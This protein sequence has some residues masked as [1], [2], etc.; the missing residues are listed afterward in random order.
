[1]SLAFK[2]DEALQARLHEVLAQL[3]AQPGNNVC[4]DCGAATP[5]W[6]SIN[7]GVFICIKCAGIHR[8]LV[9]HISKVRSITLDSWTEEQ[10]AFVARIGN[11]RANS[12]YEALNHSFDKKPEQVQRC[13]RRARCEAD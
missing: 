4:A 2:T 9:T 11:I 7:L 12:V 1:M 5:K 10:V 6:S 8:S 13:V 3:V